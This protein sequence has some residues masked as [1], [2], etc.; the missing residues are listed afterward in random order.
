MEASAEDRLT[1][2]VGKAIL[3]LLRKVVEQTLPAILPTAIVWGV[4]VWGAARVW[5]H[6][7]SVPLWVFILVLVPASFGAVAFVRIYLI[8]RPDFHV[9]VDP[10]KSFSCE[11][12]WGHVPAAQV[13]LAA[14]FANSSKYDVL[15]MYAY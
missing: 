11:A 14:T 6:Q 9:T 10:I 5:T 1:T 7:K 3:W 12:K 2:R 15:L 4:S 13:R 8:R